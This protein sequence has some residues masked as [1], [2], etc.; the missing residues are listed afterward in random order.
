MDAAPPL[1]AAPPIPHRPPMALVVS[2]DR[3]DGE[4]GTATAVV[5]EDSPFA[6]PDGQVEPVALL[7]A[8][9]QACAAWGGA[10]AA[11][12][13]D[14]PAVAFLAGVRSFEADGPAVC[15][16][17]MEIEVS[18]VRSFAGFTL[19]EA[20]LSQHGRELARASLKAF[21]P[22]DAPERG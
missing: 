5:R 9:A 1:G 19:F 13:G 21:S 4:G 3:A 12:S 11:A 6:M 10:R 20:A 15:G 18:F 16:D 7:E 14:G 17:P 8:M 22:G 2:L